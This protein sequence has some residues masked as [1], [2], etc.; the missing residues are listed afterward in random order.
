MDNLPTEILQQILQHI[1]L[2]AGRATLASSRLC[3]RKWDK[4]CRPLIFSTLTLRAT[5]ES[6]QR[7]SRIAQDESLRKYVK[8]LDFN[9]VDLPVWELEEFA[10]H[11]V[12]P[13]RD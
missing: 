2:T 8:T 1:L 12:A 7:L 13:A 9:G 10:L 11:Y 5:K 3:C 4:N 6:F